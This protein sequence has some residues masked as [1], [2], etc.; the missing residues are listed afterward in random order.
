M[1]TCAWV[2]SFS[3]SLTLSATGAPFILPSTWWLFSSWLLARFWPWL[4]LGL[5]GTAKT[6]RKSIKRTSERMQV[7]VQC[8]LCLDVSASHRITCACAKLDVLIEHVP[9]FSHQTVKTLF[10]VHTGTGTCGLSVL[11]ERPWPMCFLHG[12]QN[13]VYTLHLRF[14]YWFFFF[15]RFSQVAIGCVF[16]SQ[17]AAPLVSFVS[18]C[19]LPF[20]YPFLSLFPSTGWTIHFWKEQISRLWSSVG[21]F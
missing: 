3:P 20:S 10:S 1:T 12:P 21:T 7:L 17:V 18:V 4:L 2:L 9:R 6:Q 19:D 16:V 8:V 11:Y 14:N 13:W 5:R 15:L